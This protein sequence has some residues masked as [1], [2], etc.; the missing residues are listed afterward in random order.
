[1]NKHIILPFAVAALAL[2]FINPGMIIGDIDM[3]TAG[4]FGVLLIITCVYGYY[5]A[6]DRAHDE[7]EVMVR[8][9][10][11]RLASLVG[12]GS[13][14]AVIGVCLLSNHDIPPSV[15]VVLVAMIAAK[16][17]GQWYAC[18]YY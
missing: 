4:L 12:M 14:L 15:V 17:F 6:I 13:L 16:A 3:R 2:I 18:K 9:F 1:M 11:D 8:S 10:A 5:V 7:R